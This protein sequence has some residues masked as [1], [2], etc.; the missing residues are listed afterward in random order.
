MNRVDEALRRALELTTAPA[1]DSQSPRLRDEDDADTGDLS[2]ELFPAEQA[3][4]VET[5]RG[6]RPIRALQ[7]ASEPVVEDVIPVRINPAYHEKLVT[8]AA[9]ETFCAEQYRRLAAAV[10][11]LQVEQGL[12]RLMVS[13]AVPREGKTLTIV[14]LALTFS[15]LYQRRVLLI[16]ADLRRPSIHHVFG[17]ANQG[18]LCQVLQSESGNVQ[19]TRV[20]ERLWVLPAGIPH[21]DPMTTLAS[22]RMAQFLED[23]GSQF[24]WIL[25][26]APPVALMADAGLLV[27]VTGAVVLVIAA[28]STPHSVIE[29]AVTELGR[30]HIVGTVLNRIEGNSAEWSGYYGGVDAAKTRKTHVI[31][32]A[33]ASVERS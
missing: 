19:L 28:G 22:G 33:T 21:G 11:H 9:A 7:P 8:G 23:L 24:D 14:N 6:K 27:R 32:P 2:L 15:E 3:L 1:M 29:K 13:S 10:H 26:D 20:S 30:E 25:L 5:A 4:T 18:G 17:I 16:D 12:N 31:V